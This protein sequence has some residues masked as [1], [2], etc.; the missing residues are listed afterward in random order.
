MAKEKIVTEKSVFNAAEALIKQ[1][2]DVSDIT[3]LTIKKFLGGGSMSS[4]VPLLRDWKEAKL[5]EA[6]MAFEMPEDFKNFLQDQGNQV[7]RI[8]VAN[9]NKAFEVKFEDTR[10]NMRNLNDM[11]AEI[12]SLQD[13]VEV[14]N[15]TIEAVFSQLKEMQ[16]EFIAIFSEL[17]V[18]EKASELQKHTEV[19]KVK[20]KNVHDYMEHILTLNFSTQITPVS[21]I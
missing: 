19:S 8:A 14:A 18:Y 16:N 7:W 4:I 21:G 6:G 15:T 13:K 12:D 1:G 10:R 11:E 2:A 20:L 17:A 5:E 9:A 3:N